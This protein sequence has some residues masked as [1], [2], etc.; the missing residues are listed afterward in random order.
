MK[1]QVPEVAASDSQVRSCWER[2]DFVRAV[3]AL[4]V[5]AKPFAMNHLL[6]ASSRPAMLDQR[7]SKKNAMVSARMHKLDATGRIGELAGEDL[8]NDR[9]LVA[10]QRLHAGGNTP[11]DQRAETQNSDAGWMAGRSLS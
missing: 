1:R 2:R 5:L 6:V 9:V 8:L 3:I 4:G 7:T 10:M 11:R